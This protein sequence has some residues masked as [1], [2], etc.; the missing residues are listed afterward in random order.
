MDTC[1]NRRCFCAVWQ[2]VLALCLT[3]VLVDGSAVISAVGLSAVV[4][5]ADQF[6]IVGVEFFVVG[7]L[8]FELL[9]QL[10]LE[11][12]LEG[13]ALPVVDS[14]ERALA[15]RVHERHHK[16]IEAYWLCP[17]AWLLAVLDREVLVPL[18]AGESVAVE[19]LVFLEQRLGY[20]AGQRT[21]M[22]RY[23]VFGSGLFGRR[24]LALQNDVNIF[25]YCFDA[26]GV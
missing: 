21:H 22:L 3:S 10:L 18:H 14:A 4:F 9:L 24:A 5:V 2:V 19:G 15:R 8:F 7:E 17:G 1:P 26:Q 13:L 12:G 23:A 11:D 25:T 6:E 16:I 20:P